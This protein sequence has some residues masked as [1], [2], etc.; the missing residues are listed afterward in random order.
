[1]LDNFAP[2]AR[3]RNT[4]SQLPEI[5]LLIATDCISEG[6]NLQDCD[7]VVN[8]DIHWNPVRLIQRFGRID[9]IGSRHIQIRMV[10]YWPTVD[11]ERYLKL[12][13]RVKARMVLVDMA[14]TGDS[15]LLDESKVE[16]DL[17]RRDEQLQL[18][19]DGELPD[20][21][22][23][24]GGLSFS[25]LSLEHFIHQLWN[26][27]ERNRD[28]LEKIPNGIYAVVEDEVGQDEGVIFV[29]KHKNQRKRDA[30]KYSYSPVMPYYLIY[31]SRVGEIKIGC[32]NTQDLLNRF[33]EI[34][35]DK[36]RVNEKLYR[37]FDEEID[38]GRK[39]E[40]YDWLLDKSVNHIQE[41]FQRRS[42]QERGKRG[43]TMP[44]LSEQA[45]SPDDFELITWL[46]VR[47]E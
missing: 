46:V 47:N 20:P 36:K 8:Y 37:A 31:I 15:N 27:L 14:G 24:S 33:N 2:V 10:N 4:K 42:T 30:A 6:Q 19:F 40:L 29:L 13:N 25:D 43:F 41:T 1:M 9:R 17:K 16:Y 12:E 32:T 11:L 22:A 39:L 26:Y 5:D 28:R 45:N 3:G 23:A 38:G 7:L 34:T 18:Q 21:D 35:F 44:K